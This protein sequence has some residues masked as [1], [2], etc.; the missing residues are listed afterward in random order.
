[1]GLL[2]K[3]KCPKCFEK[4]PFYKYRYRKLGIFL[5][6]IY[7]KCPSCGKISVPKINLIKAILNPFFLVLLTLWIIIVKYNKILSIMYDTF[8]HFFSVIIFCAVNGLLVVMWY[9]RAYELVVVDKINL[10]YFKLKDCLAIIF[11]FISIILFSLYI[12]FS[13]ENLAIILMV[14]VL[15]FIYRYFKSK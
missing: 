8:D 13:L 14:W 2:I 5:D 9:T 15:I 12:G 11:F 1:M 4:I 7:Y 6:I 10:R 3:F